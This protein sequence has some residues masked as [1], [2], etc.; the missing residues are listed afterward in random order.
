MR[1]TACGATLASGCASLYA[2]RSVSISVSQRSSCSDGRA[3]TC[4][5]APTTP[6]RHKA[7]T[8]GGKE[9]K[10]IGAP[11]TGTDKLCFSRSG[12]VIF[13][14]TISP[15]PMLQ[16]ALVSPRSHGAE[17]LGHRIGGV[18][19]SAGREGS[20]RDQ[21][22]HQVGADRR[23]GNYRRMLIQEA[24]VQAR[25]GKVR[26]V[27]QAAQ[28]GGISLAAEHREPAERFMSARSCFFA[29]AA[30]HDDF[31]QHRIKCRRN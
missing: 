9:T 4:G 14:P 25:R 2:R 15:A 10:N 16:A 31:G 30:M 1:L 11:I 18:A 20:R 22:Q 28:E 12:T 26:V 6:A 24:G 5:N 19:N 27:G 13:E 8:R 23:L 17:N 3:L 21:I 29:V 7:V